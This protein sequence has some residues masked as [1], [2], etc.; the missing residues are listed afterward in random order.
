MTPV[1][2]PHNDVQYGTM[3]VTAADVAEVM[4]AE[5]KIQVGR[6]EVCAAP[7]TAA[8]VER[9]PDLP[10]GWRCRCGG[11]VEPRD[12]AEVIGEFQRWQLRRR[13]N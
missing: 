13:T 2:F 11:H 8:E 6:C 7:Y 4:R 1:A 3:L 10:S 5:G 9:L 12:P